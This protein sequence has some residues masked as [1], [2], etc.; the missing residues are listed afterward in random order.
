MGRPSVSKYLDE[1][2]ATL[3]LEDEAPFSD[4][5]VPSRALRVDPGFDPNGLTTVSFDLDLQGYAADRRAAFAA[6]FI[7]RASALPDVT[8]VA[9]ADILPLGGEMYATG[10]GRRGPS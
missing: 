10:S 8:S 6:R 3:A 1:T 2:C 5:M 9:A 7:E 4:T